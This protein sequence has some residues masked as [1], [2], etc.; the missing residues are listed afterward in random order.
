MEGSKKRKRI[1]FTSSSPSAL[2]SDQPLG[3]S[4]RSVSSKMTETQSPSPSCVSMKSK[5][6]M[7]PPLNFGP[8]KK[9]SCSVCN[10][11][12][13]DPVQFICGHWLCK[14]CTSSDQ[15]QSD[16]AADD[17]CPKCGKT[18][19]RDPQRQRD[20]EEESGISPLL[21]GKKNFREAMKKK[22]VLTSEGCGDQQNSLNS[23]YTELYIITGQSKG[24]QAEHEFGPVKGQLKRRISFKH[25]IRLS[26]IFKSLPGQQKPHRTVL[27]KGSAGIGKSFAVQ[28]FILDWAEEEA[29]QDVDFVFFIAFRE[30]NL[31][32]CEKSLHELLT[33]FH[34]VLHDHDLKDSA[35]F[36]KSKVIV[37]LDGLDES[38]LQLDFDKT[39]VVTSV[40]EETSLGNLLVNLIQGNLL[41]DARL[42]ITSRP[43][44]ANQI[45]AKYVDMVT[46]IRGFSDPE[47][48]KYFRR[49]FSQDLS[50]ADRIISHIRSSQSLDI[51]CQIPIFCWITAVLFEEVFGGD[52]DAE[53]PQT[54]TE[55]M[56]HFLFAQ[57]K[58]RS[59][60]YDKKTKDNKEELLKT[61][62]DFLLKLGK[63]AFVHLLK[64][65]LIFYEEDL[66]NC[67]IDVK[68]A[69]I[70]S[71]F[72]SSILREERLFSQ[73][74][75]FF[76]VH[77]TIQEFFAAL[78]VYDCF[79]NKNL[80][81]L[82]EFLNLKDK[83]Q[84]LLDLLK[85][86]VDK[87]LEKNNGHL[88][89]FL[90]FLLGL[91]VEPNRRLLQGLLTSPDPNQETE[92]KI[93]TYL[94]SIRRKTISPDSCINLFRTM[95]EMRDNKVKDEIQE[96]LKLRDRSKTD[97]TPLHCSAL[98]Y[99]LQISKDDLDVLDL[100]SYNTSD[101][102]RRRLIPAVR[103]SRK[104]ILA[105][106]KVTAEWVEHLVMSLTL[107]HSCLRDLDLSNNDLRDS[108]VKQLCH[109][110]SSQC[111]RVKTLRLSGCLVTDTGCAFLASALQSNP[112][113]LMELDLSYNNPG[114]SGK[115]QLTELKNDPHYKLSI[116]NV[117]HCGCHRMMPGF[118][119]YACE[120]TL[121]PN[122][123]HKNLR[124]SEDNR[125][126][127]W[128]EEQ[129]TYPDH[130][131]RFDQCQQ[132]LCKQG[133]DGR[134][135]FEL[136]V[137][138][139]FNIGLTYRNISRKGDD[140]D[141]K[142]GDSNKS[143]SL[144]CSD[145]GCYVLHNNTSV[146]VTSI[147]SRSS[148]V[149]VYLD[150]PAG[151]LSFYRVTSDSR[152]RLHTFQSMFSETLYPA[153]ELHT[154]SSVFIC[155]PT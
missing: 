119:K 108:G 40:S 94:K 34:P 138:E 155:Q 111:C 105:D 23:I 80:G 75:V 17:S 96:Y 97:L 149:G 76:F 60:K 51:M 92:K 4:S 132:V 1:D 86:T 13:R 146:S 79:I 131:E 29:N 19:R 130:P 61:H 45:P 150:K 32:T 120:L 135:Y 148:R 31:S 133:L 35:V 101:E 15:D 104:A 56:S 112:S 53:T 47:K 62:R 114:T 110:L 25:S 22:F 118:R 2:K 109:G 10:E 8:E 142:L 37:I 78:Y 77:L 73:K 58:R 126:V 91:M 11:D 43:A 106:C 6:S 7:F 103:S 141:C 52:E 39:K 85:M 125:K 115:N 153:V 83:E 66:E 144:I 20:A 89:Y 59:R 127:T 54:L 44:A 95:V 121:D 139:P 55:M 67:G 145:T 123:V 30:L 87:V 33:E 151:A 152:T 38:R 42:W 57:T 3:S 82:K 71:G 65:N 14:Q 128:V 113:H 124:L 16:S 70:Y 69:S 84:T 68:E 88:Y 93:L 137:E 26:D 72:C 50:L 98:A 147:S 116:L 49:R 102:G 74:K 90:R 24:P 134:C 99:M 143:W 28:K 122:T 129:Q 107:P 63:L 117:E 140:S 5:A 48:E 36:V 41:P 154:H 100:K 12:L 18:L 46:E 21:K 136:E 64:N 81:E 27:T 9:Q